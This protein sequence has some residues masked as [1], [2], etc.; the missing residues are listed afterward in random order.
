MSRLTLDQYFAGCYAELIFQAAFLEESELTDM[1]SVIPHGTVDIRIVE[2]DCDTQIIICDNVISVV[3]NAELEC[4]VISAF[5]E[6]IQADDTY[7]IEQLLL[8]NDIMP[9]DVMSLT[10][11]A[12]NQF[13]TE[14]LERLDITD[15]VQARYDNLRS[16]DDTD[17][18]LELLSY[19]NCYLNPN[20]E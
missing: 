16:D 8:S 1:I 3:A 14:Q 6:T 18:S 12:L 2:T 4:V 7:E 9:S 17:K 19:L 10:D 5:G 13:F 11:S 15:I 20:N